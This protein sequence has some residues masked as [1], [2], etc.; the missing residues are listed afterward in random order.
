[1]LKFQTCQM[2]VGRETMSIPTLTEHSIRHD[3][4]QDNWQAEW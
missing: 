3:K 1:M 2:D 4:R